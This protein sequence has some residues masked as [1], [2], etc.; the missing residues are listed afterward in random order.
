MQQII[1]WLNTNGLG[2]LI[3]GV[4][5][6]PL[7]KWGTTWLDG[8][9]V[10]LLKTE[11]EKLKEKSNATTVLSQIAADDAIIEIVEAAIPEVVFELSS[12]IQAHIS[13]GKLEAIN[14]NDFGE[15]LWK[16]IE[17]QIKGGANDY[18]KNSSFTDGKAL[19]M[20]IA[21]RFFKTEQVQKRGLTTP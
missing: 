9:G 3:L 14:W 10:S 8:K 19:V 6:V 16:K 18:L 17:P 7:L 2:T 4:I 12:E 13:N 1:D 21:Q 5:L 11:L 15:R 20:M